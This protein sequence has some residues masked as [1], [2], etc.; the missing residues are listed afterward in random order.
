MTTINAT[1]VARSKMMFVMVSLLSG[2][3]ESSCEKAPPLFAAFSLAEMDVRHKA[4][5]E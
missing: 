4:F 1:I 3:W 2:Y 5:V